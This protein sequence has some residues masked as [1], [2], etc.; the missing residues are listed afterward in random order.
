MP[1]RTPGRDAPLAV[2]NETHL[3]AAQTQDV[4]HRA[5]TLRAGSGVP[6][7]GTMSIVV[8]DAVQRAERKPRRAVVTRHLQRVKRGAV[9]GVLVRQFPGQ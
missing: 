2:V 7:F 4:P 6:D 5:L 8:D 3:V 9:P 1:P